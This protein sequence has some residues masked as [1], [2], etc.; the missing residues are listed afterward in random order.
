MSQINHAEWRSTNSLSTPADVSDKFKPDN[1]LPPLSSEQTVQAVNDLLVKNNY[2]CVERRLNDPEL[3]GQRYGLVSF[4]PAKGATPNSQG[5]YGFA[6]LR[7]NFNTE[8]DAND[9]AEYLIRNID[10]YHH[11]YTTYVGQ[12]FPLTTTSDFSSEVKSIDIRKEV[13]DAYNEDV[14]NKREKEKK[15]IE[16]IKEREKKLLEDVDKPVDEKKEEEYVTLRVKKAQLT[17]SYIETLK[18][19]RQMQTLIAKTMIQIDEL[20]EKDPHLKDLFYTRYKQ[21]REEAGIPID[22][23]KLNE[24]FVK[25]MVEDIKLPEIQQ[26]YQELKNE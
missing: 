10:S 25:F 1:T 23:S 8:D 21:A 18:K 13:T 14:K 19:I 3:N 2:P 22:D 26:L 11:I 20:D 15:E 6:K 17:W 9:R 5:I 7:G 24:S 16:E 12:P 4:V